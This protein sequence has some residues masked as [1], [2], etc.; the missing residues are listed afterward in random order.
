MP[1]S[2]FFCE[3]CALDLMWHGIAQAEEDDYDKKDDLGI[4]EGVRQSL[5]LNRDRDKTA[6]DN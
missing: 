1:A 5:L 6:N 3:Q 4:R 2:G